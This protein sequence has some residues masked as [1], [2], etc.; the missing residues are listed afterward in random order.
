MGKAR[1]RQY[2][3]HDSS[4]WIESSGI[5]MRLLTDDH[6]GA[7]HQRFVLDMRNGQSLLVAHNIDLVRRVPLGMGDKIS[8]RGLYEWNDLGGVVHWTHHDPRGVEE[9]GYIKFRQEIY[10]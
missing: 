1:Q 5:V 8:F 6:E 3:R 4:T 2:D 7:R 9:G 10:Q